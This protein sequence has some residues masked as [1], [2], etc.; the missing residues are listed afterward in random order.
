[1]TDETSRQ[2]PH[3]SFTYAAVV[4]EELH[5]PSSQDKHLSGQSR[6]VPINNGYSLPNK[7]KQN[8]SNKHYHTEEGEFL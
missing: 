3:D 4:K 8:L 5:S 6:N 1:M 2:L 7:T